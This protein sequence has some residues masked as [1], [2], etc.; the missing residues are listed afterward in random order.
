MIDNNKEFKNQYQ[1]KAIEGDGK[2][3]ISPD[4]S[5]NR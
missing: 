4:F 3:G 2:A 5:S 1:S